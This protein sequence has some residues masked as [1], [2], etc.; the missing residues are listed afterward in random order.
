MK[1]KSMKSI[2]TPIKQLVEIHLT[3]LEDKH[4]PD[5]EEHVITRPPGDQEKQLGEASGG[6]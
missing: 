1:T 6:S 5:F 2:Q 4:D 3:Q